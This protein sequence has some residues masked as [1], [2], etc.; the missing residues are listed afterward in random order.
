M[1]RL[2]QA[3]GID[4]LEISG[5]DFNM[6][7]GEKRAFYLPRALEVRDTVSI[8]LILVGGIFSRE[9][10]ERILDAGIPFVA[11]SRALICQPDFIARMERGEASACLQCN[12]CYSIYRKRPVRC[13]RHSAE[14]PQ[15]K[16]N[17]QIKTQEML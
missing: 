1:S 13:V 5:S 4:A 6:R 16:E 10:A 11:F 7:K 9:E 3:A 2:Y 15:L 17:F 8:P 12:S 14:I